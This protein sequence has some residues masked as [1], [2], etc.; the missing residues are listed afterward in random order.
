MSLCSSPSSNEIEISIFGNSF[1]ESILIHLGNNEWI[2]VDS[3]KDY[4]NKR[5]IALNYLDKIGVDY[6]AV[7]AAVATHWHDDHICGLSEIMIKCK[8]AAFICSAAINS[9]EFNEFIFSD[10]DLIEGRPGNY[11]LRQIL[12]ELSK[13]K[14]NAMYALENR[15]LIDNKLY[16]IYSLSPSDY[17]M[18]LAQKEIAVLL[19]KKNQPR[20]GIPHVHPNHTG[21]VLLIV[22]NGQGIL[23]GGDLEENGDSRTG[24]SKII[25]SVRPVVKSNNFK[26]PHHGSITAH[27]E[28]IWISLLEKEPISF[29]TSF[30]L[31]S[32]A[33]PKKADM[34]RILSHT[35]NAWITTSPDEKK[36][37]KRDPMAERTIK[38]R[39]KAI[40]AMSDNGHIRL[41]CPLGTK[42]WKP[43][44]FGPA[45]SLEECLAVK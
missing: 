35:N 33:L 27:H 38:E 6:G 10:S 36:Q 12:E 29:L 39:V 22:V 2:I 34:K 44:L 4:L 18:L 7:K 8:N 31:G 25:D 13:R 11:E 3:F 24:W 28:G 5:A 9:K 23:L 20:K 19:P 16:K 21:I 32:C 41:R 37:V 30:I 40:R 14:G 17:A 43:E 15:K 45:L 26:I 42:E 1:G